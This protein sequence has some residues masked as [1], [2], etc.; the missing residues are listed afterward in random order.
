MQVPEASGLWGTTKADK[1]GL[2]LNPSCSET[3]LCN[4]Q[5]LVINQ[6]TPGAGPVDFQPY[7]GYNSI[8]QKGNNGNSSYN[9]LQVTYRHSFGKG[10]SFQTAYTWS[11]AIDNSTS[12]YLQ[13]FQIDNTNM[14]RWKATGD[15][16]RT[17]MLTLNYIYDL[18]FFRQS[19]NHWAKTLI[20]GWTI[21]GI[22]SLYTG[23][24]ID[25]E[26]GLSGF[27]T[28][29]NGTTKCNSTG[30][31]KI[32]KGTFQDPTYGPTPLW[33]NSGEESLV[34]ASQLLSNGEPGMFGYEGRNEITG[35]GR[36]NTDLALLKDF[37]LPWFKGEHST[38]QFR[39]EAFNA[40]NHPQWQGI[41][42][43]CA[44]NANQDGTLAFGRTCG[45]ITET[46]SSGGIARYN[47]GVGEVN[48]TWG[49]R[50]VQFG[51]KFLF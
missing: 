49:P 12:T 22:T 15:N 17:H 50:I 36:N 42:T 23:S 11:H 33:Y 37:A 44:N 8:V 32:A 18:P 27:N 25:Y 28:G 38:L 45:A 14:E 10:L 19:S 20:G 29:V 35:P 2:G 40:F 26:C 4:V 13:N 47:Y 7:R 1:T 51:L 43:G 3:G 5:D 24:P 41:N 16:N 6:E 21:S 48:S 30:P 34:T 31:L 39:W 46:T 9:A